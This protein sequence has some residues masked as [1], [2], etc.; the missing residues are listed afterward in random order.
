MMTAVGR[1]ASAVVEEVRRQFR[2]HPG[3]MTRTETDCARAATCPRAAIREMIVPSLLPVLSPIVLFCS[4]SDCRSH[5]GAVALRAVGRHRHRM[6]VVISMTS[7]A[8][9]DNAKK[10]IEDGHYG[11]GF[12]GAHAAVTATPS[13]IPTDTAPAVNPMIN[14]TNIVVPLLLAVLAHLT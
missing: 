14:I 1:A 2:E 7:M 4:C 8:A 11:G 13:A 6:F 12:G 9:W 5:F 10:Y 3:I